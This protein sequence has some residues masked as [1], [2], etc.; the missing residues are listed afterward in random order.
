MRKINSL[1]KGFTLI[2]L[3]VVIAIIGLLSSVILASL[4]SARDK[5]QIAKAQVDMRRIV[6]AITIAQGE[7]GKSLID[8]A[9]ATNC[10]QCVCADPT[11][12]TCSTQFET[13][14]TQIQTATKGL[15]TNLNGIRDPWGRPYLIDANQREFTCSTL[16]GFGVYAGGTFTITRIP[17]IPLSPTCP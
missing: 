4:K 10:G 11:S 16:D 14:L 1:H 17:T 5:A 15:V 8:F 2:E 9:P 13:A 7:Q 6:S 12:A 3:L